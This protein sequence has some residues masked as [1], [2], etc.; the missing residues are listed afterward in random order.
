MARRAAA[1]VQDGSAVGLGTGRAAS[2]F[3]AALA[4]R[5]RRGLE[6]RCVATS[7]A[8]EAAARD[9]GLPLVSLDEVGELDLDVDGADE[10]DPALDLVKGHG[11]A[12]VRERIVATASRRLV[13]LAGTEKLVATLGARGR[14]PV[15]VVPFGWPLRARRLSGLGCP[16]RRRMGAGAPFIT[17]NGNNILDCTVEP[18]RR[19]GRTPA[20]DQRHPRSGGDRA[21]PGDGRYRLHRGCAR[22]RDGAP[23]GLT[24]KPGRSRPARGTPRAAVRR[25]AVSPGRRASTGPGRRPS[26]PGARLVPF[27]RPRARPPRGRL[28][29]VEGSNGRRCR[30]QALAR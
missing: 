4:E 19:S 21:L 8:I 1:L 5:A 13:I 9:L 29:G 23:A 16:S 3:L 22:E 7:R 17:D 12:L 20:E 26:L 24:G 15:E 30:R 2:A 14:L 6:V 18:N 25:I 27:S 28:V 11:G 10:V